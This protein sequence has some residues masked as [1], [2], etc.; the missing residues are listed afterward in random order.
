MADEEFE[1]VEEF[2]DAEIDP[3]E[4]DVEEL[5]DELDEDFVVHEA[6]DP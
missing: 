5:D 3:D 1:E 2:V 4:L 6:D